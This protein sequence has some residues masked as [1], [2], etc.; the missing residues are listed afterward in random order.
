MTA[1]DAPLVEKAKKPMAEDKSNPHEHLLLKIFA[2]VAGGLIMV[3]VL[4]VANHMINV[5]VH[6]PRA[7]KKTQD[8]EWWLEYWRTY[9]KPEFEEIKE[10]IKEKN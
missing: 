7:V 5:E 3:I 1:R 6:Q 9:A 2:T 10:L 4:A 8:H